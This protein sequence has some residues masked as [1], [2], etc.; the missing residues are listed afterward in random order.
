MSSLAFDII[1]PLYYCHYLI[2]I[3]IIDVVIM[4]LFLL[5]TTNLS[6]MLSFDTIV[7]YQYH[8][9]HNYNLGCIFIIIVNIISAV[10][11]SC[12]GRQ[13]FS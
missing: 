3:I 9:Q 11:G 12:V 6:S 7:K 13:S 4:K 5:S 1:I 8:Q 2:N 10:Q